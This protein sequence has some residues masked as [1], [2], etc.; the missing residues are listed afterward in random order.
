VNTFTT[1]ETITAFFSFTHDHP[2]L[3]LLDVHSK[4]IPIEI[5]TSYIESNEQDLN[6]LKIGPQAFRGQ[7][8][9]YTMRSRTSNFIV[10][11]LEG[12]PH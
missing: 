5:N 4:I 7:T 9:C 8:D 1:Y 3:H 6:E 12:F 2:A 11:Q 10:E